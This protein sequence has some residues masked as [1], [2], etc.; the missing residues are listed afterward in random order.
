[1]SEI[2]IGIREHLYPDW[3]EEMY[4][5]LSEEAKARFVKLVLYVFVR[6][7]TKDRMIG[8]EPCKYQFEQ[9]LIDSTDRWGST[10][11]EDVASALLTMFS[12]WTWNRA[13][14][15]GD[16]HRYAD[17]ATPAGGS[18]KSEREAIP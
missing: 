12:L 8:D 6:P 4:K 14:A 1:M 5:G 2:A 13:E 18:E 7:E 15:L 11:A 3:V 16:T 9:C 17:E 10:S